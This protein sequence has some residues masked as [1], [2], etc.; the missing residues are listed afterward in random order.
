MVN[1]A[2]DAVNALCDHPEI[3]AVS[4][5]G[6]SNIAE[7]VYQRCRALN[8]RCLA[9]GGAKNHLVALNDC[10]HEA[11]ARDIA[12][13]A[14]GCAG[15]RC[16]AASVLLLVGDTGDLLDRVVA[17]AQALELGTESGKVG[18]II[19]Q[20]SRDKMHGYVDRAAESG[21]KILVDGRPGAA[22][23]PG[24][25]FGPT[26]MVF[27]DKTQECLHDEIFGPVLSVLRVSSWE[28]AIEIEN[29][30]PYGNAASIYT[31]VGANAEWFCDRFRAGMLGVNIG[32]P[33]PR[34]PL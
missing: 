12:A 8:K 14:F 25:W 6:S 3:A 9:L 22:R 16:M 26:V 32:V 4:F 31:S 2:V 17:K 33:V 5:V 23:S 29:N 27:T 24:Y 11:A 13:S 28:E 20:R 7:L 1:G 15:Q 30:N 19:D 10:D 18:A 34:E 21:A